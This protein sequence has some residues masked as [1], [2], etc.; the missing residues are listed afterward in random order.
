[1]REATGVEQC[2]LT[3]GHVRPHLLA[4]FAGLAGDFLSM[5]CT[6]SLKPLAVPA[7]C[8]SVRPFALRKFRS[9]SGAQLCDTGKTWKGGGVGEPRRTVDPISN[10]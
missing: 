6:Q 7:R 10:G 5:G 4:V 3:V 2:T 1:M 8:C 9:R